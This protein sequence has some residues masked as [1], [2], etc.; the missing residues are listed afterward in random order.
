M[1]RIENAGWT[2]RRRRV[3]SSPSLTTSA[4][5]PATAVFTPASVRPTRRRGPGVSTLPAYR[6]FG[7]PAVRGEEDVRGI[8]RI[9]LA[10]L[11]ALPGLAAVASPARAT[12][13]TF[14]VSSAAD[15]DD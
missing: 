11:L 13:A 5:A 1:R 14:T 4:V 12:S 7:V 6:R 2:R 3:W 15:H 9:L 10:T 8:R